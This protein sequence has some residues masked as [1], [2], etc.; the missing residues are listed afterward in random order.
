MTNMTS[1]VQVCLFCMNVNVEKPGPAP[2]LHYFKYGC[3]ASEWQ[4]NELLRNDVVLADETAALLIFQ[5]WE[6]ISGCL[7]AIF[8]FGYVL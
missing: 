8:L 1:L 5:G 4:Q 6:I 7:F 2:G 3:G